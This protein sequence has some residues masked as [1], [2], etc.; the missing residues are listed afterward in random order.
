HRSTTHR[1]L[2]VLERHRFIRRSPTLGKYGLGLK[3]FELGSRA[4]AQVN[5]QER[6]QPFLRRLVELT[7]ETAHICVLDG[8]HAVSIANAEGPRTLRTPATIGRRGA[9]NW[10][11]GG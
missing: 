8:T 10:T 2:Q 7:G 3:L 4:V 5:I 11:S 6:G 9:G 1:L